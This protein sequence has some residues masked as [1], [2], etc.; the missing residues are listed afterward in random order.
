MERTGRQVPEGTEGLRVGLTGERR[1]PKFER[2]KP[3]GS[4]G[5]GEI[6]SLASCLTD[7]SFTQVPTSGLEGA[8]ELP[9]GLWDCPGT[10]REDAVPRL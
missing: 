6:T 8:Y 9:R 5:W 1:E 2:A 10:V 7:I 3:W 4:Q